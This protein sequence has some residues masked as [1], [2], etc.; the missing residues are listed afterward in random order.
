MQAQWNLS[1]PTCTKRDSLL[2]VQWNLPNP[3]CTKRHSLCRNRQSVELHSVKHTDNG[4]KGIINDRLHRE[5]DYSG[6]GLDRF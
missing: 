5:T 6:V 4:Q 3:T 2:Q 1:N